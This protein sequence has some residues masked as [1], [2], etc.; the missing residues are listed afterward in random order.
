MKRRGIR[1]A[2]VVAL[3]AALAASAM[4][5]SA[6]AT[7]TTGVTCRST[8]FG[9]AGFSDSHCVNAVASGAAFVHE[10]LPQNTSTP[11]TI[12][13]GGAPAA[14]FKATLAGFTLAV[15]CNGAS[16]TGIL[17]TQGANPPRE[18]YS[19]GTAEITFSL[20]GIEAP[21][22]FTCT[23]TG[24]TVQT[25]PLLWTT[26]GKGMGVEFAPETGTTLAEATISGCSGLAAPLNGTW[27]LSGTVVLTPHGATLTSTHAETTMQGTLTLG[28]SNPA[29]L[30]S[31]L[32]VK[33]TIT[34]AGIAFTT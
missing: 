21:L 17:N 34:G 3:L 19:W 15:S 2:A 30:T 22:S 8:G 4:T 31:N 18:M 9:G 6:S 24:G 10:S 26:E 7:N 20:C 28:G 16:G 1:I 25:R 14:T 32:T 29:G 23:V 33:G 5:A 12:T 27:A 11:I 13:G